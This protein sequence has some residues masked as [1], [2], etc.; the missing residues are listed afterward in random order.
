MIVDYSHI[1]FHCLVCSRKIDHL[2][3]WIVQIT[4]V[5]VSRKQNE[6]F[7]QNLEENVVCTGPSIC[8]SFLLTNQKY[9]ILIA[10]TV[11]L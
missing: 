8:K 2:I 3:C 4:N 6:S 1:I 7:H 10:L 11:S 9:E 5:T